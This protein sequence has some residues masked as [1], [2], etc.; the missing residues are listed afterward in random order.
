MPHKVGFC[1]N[2][3]FTDFKTKCGSSRLNLYDNNKTHVYT[4]QDVITKD[5]L[6]ALETM[7][8]YLPQSRSEAFHF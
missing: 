5:S 6:K 8:S 7:C 4:R 3:V 2:N 1:Q